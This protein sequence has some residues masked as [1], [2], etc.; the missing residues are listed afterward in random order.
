LEHSKYAIRI[1]LLLHRN[2]EMTL[3]AI[4][5]SIRTSPST[6]VRALRVLE[7]KG[8]VASAQ[9]QSGRKR[10]FYSLTRLG[11]TVAMHPP[12]AWNSVYE[13][14]VGEDGKVVRR[15]VH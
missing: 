4:L 12:I 7:L 5:R 15:A 1:V 11:V 14:P 13:Q 6:V 8:F 10:R 2:R 3:S 9:E